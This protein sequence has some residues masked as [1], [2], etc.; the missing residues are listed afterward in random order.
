VPNWFLWPL[1]LW[2]LV[3]G[4]ICLFILGLGIASRLTRMAGRIKHIR[5]PGREDYP[6]ENASASDA[7]DEGPTLSSGEQAA[8][9]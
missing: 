4:V 8:A 7:D 9:S 3:S 1:M 6:V 5:S 2:A